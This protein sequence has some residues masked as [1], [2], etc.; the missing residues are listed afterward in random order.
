M[1]CAGVHPGPVIADE[2]DFAVDSVGGVEAPVAVPEVADLGWIEATDTAVS[3]VE[4]PLARI[5]VIQTQCQSFDVAALGAVEFNG[6]EI[7]AAVPHSVAGRSACHVG[8]VGRTGEGV[9]HVVQ[10]K[11]EV[12]EKRVEVMGAVVQYR[13]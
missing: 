9:K 6:V 1:R 7:G 3:P 10:V 5:A 8:P 12:A 4:P 13:N 11:G 2:D